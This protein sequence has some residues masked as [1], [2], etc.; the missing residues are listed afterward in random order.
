M[1]LRRTIGIASLAL[2]MGCSGY[3][4]RKGDVFYENLAFNKAIKHYEKANKKGD[5]AHVVSKLAS[6]H[7]FQNNPK[8]AEPLYAQ[9]VT[10]DGVSEFEYLNYGKVLMAT[11]KH[12]EALV[13]IDRY[14][15]QHPNDVV[16]Q[17][18]KS[19]CLSVNDR[20]RDTTLYSLTPIIV[21]DMSS[22]F[23]IIEYQDG[24]VFNADREVFLPSKRAAWTGQSYLNLYYME[25]D[26]EGNWMNP[27][28]LRGDITGPFHDGPATFSKDGNT[29]YF[30]R[31]N[32]FRRKLKA[33][34]QNESNLKI[35]KA[36]LIDGKWKKLEELPF[37]SDNYSV[38]HPSL[39]ADGRTLYFVSDMPGGHGGTDIY[40]SE[41]VDGKWSDPQNLGPVVNTAGNE[42][43][44]YIHEDGSLYFSSN[45]H[46][47]MGGLD[48]FITYFTGTEWA[49]PENLNYPINSVADDFAF[50][51]NKDTRTG[52]VSSSRADGDGMYKFRKNDPTFHLYGF[53]RKK[54]TQIP[55]E[56]VT[57]EITE[58][59]TYNVIGKVSGQDGRFDLKL[60][61]NKEYLL[62][63]TKEGCFTRTDKIST[64]GLKFSENFYADFEVEEIVIGKPIVLENIYYDFDKWNIRPDAAMELDKLVKLLKDN[65]KIHI[66]MGSHTD[67]RGAD[68]YNMI[69]STRRAISAVR[70]LI[71]NGIE[72]ER[73]TW[74]GFGETELVN[75]CG[76]D[77][78]CTEAE[79]QQNRRT[80][81]RVTKIDK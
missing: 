12:D 58:A 8:K 44:P 24:V 53:A 79:H 30:T 60:E 25:K 7:V 69:L 3:H 78:R 57:V 35:F 71:A 46:N 37:N 2:L 38:G 23:S 31:S 1:R 51:I 68:N 75:H 36:T 32:Y 40:K 55:V 39:S 33:N 77:V 17:M 19:S 45:A 48:V 9:L 34:E 29:V 54:G 63:C 61:P 41:L 43:F 76:N 73:L 72:A 42:M 52:F 64:V 20:F 74:K 22:T 6:S 27:E 56:G 47:S 10:M 28:V 14:L 67:S 62:L 59:D 4:T 5:N 16:A 18:L 13:W 21:E 50:S 80:E 26:E 70:Y 11:G 65:P 49:K 15:K 66:Q 81:F